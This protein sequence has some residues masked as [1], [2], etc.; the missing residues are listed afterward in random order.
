M[1]KEEEEEEEERDSLQ[2]YLMLLGKT[3]VRCKYFGQ[4]DHFPVNTSAAC[5][6]KDFRNKESVQ[7]SALFENICNNKYDHEDGISLPASMTI[8]IIILFLFSS[9]QECTKNNLQTVQATK[10]D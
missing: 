9:S 7:N 10:A 6:V 2:S 5:I 4:V 8:I 1:R 3:N